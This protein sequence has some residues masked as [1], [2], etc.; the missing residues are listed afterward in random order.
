METNIIL[1]FSA[2]GMVRAT[3]ASVEP[4][5]TDLV[6]RTC[7]EVV[8]LQASTERQAKPGAHG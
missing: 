3:G 6:V 8:R 5:L 1:F 4:R 7:D 2:A